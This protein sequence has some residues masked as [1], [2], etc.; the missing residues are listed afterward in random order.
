MHKDDIDVLEI[1]DNKLR[2]SQQNFNPKSPPARKDS[3][4]DI[5]NRSFYDGNGRY[6]VRTQELVNHYL[7]EKPTYD[8]RKLDFFD[9]TLAQSRSQVG[10]PQLNTINR[11]SQEYSRMF[12][13][14]KNSQ[15]ARLLSESRQMVGD[16]PLAH[17]SSLANI[18]SIM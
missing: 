15:I 3:R 12:P 16:N 17:S 9:E 13:S 18:R 2:E 8:T 4:N 14:S 5:W 10:L 6:S 1:Y 11:Q 7:S